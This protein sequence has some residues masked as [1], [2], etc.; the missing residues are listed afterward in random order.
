MTSEVAVAGGGSR[1]SSGRSAGRAGSPGARSRGARPR[2][3]DPADPRLAPAVVAQWRAVADAVDALGAGA[4]AAPS[5]LAGWTVADLVM[6]VARSAA[7][8]TEALSAPTPAG[9]QTDAVGYLTGTGARAEAIAEQARALAREVTGDGVTADELT[10]DEVTADEVM[11]DEVRTDEAVGGAAGE[12][13]ARAVRQRLR[14]EVEAAAAALDQLGASWADRLV[15]TPGGAMR[16]G[17]FLLTRAVEGVVHGLDL[18]VDPVRDALRVVV[19]LFTAALA[20]RAPG[21]SV[22]LRVPP[23]AAVQLVEGPRHTRGTPPNVVEADPVSFV[24][25]ASGRLAWEDAVADGRLT[26][27]GERADLRAHLPLLR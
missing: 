22:E 11:A 3:V 10:A 8:L 25:V 1:S 24:L 4:L 18:G 5:A 14:G 20:E 13:G 6:H 2:G 27:S 7:A 15:A 16:L 12:A 9:A 17:E 23:F 26:A 21:R 19:R